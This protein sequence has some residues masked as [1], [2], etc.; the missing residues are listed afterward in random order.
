MRDIEVNLYPDF[1]FDSGYAPFS[2]ERGLA[3]ALGNQIFIGQCDSLGHEMLELVLERK[4]K[5]KGGFHCENEGCILNKYGGNEI[6]DE[7]QDYFKKIRHIPFELYV[8]VYGY[9]SKVLL[10]EVNSYLQKLRELFDLRVNVAHFEKI[11]ETCQC[12]YLVISR[13]N[14]ELTGKFRKSHNSEIY[15]L[16]PQNFVEEFSNHNNCVSDAYRFPSEDYE[17]YIIDPA[18]FEGFIVEG[19]RRKIIAK[20][21]LKLR[22]KLVEDRIIFKKALYEL[23]RDDEIEAC[24]KNKKPVDKDAT[25]NSLEEDIKGFTNSVGLINKIFEENNL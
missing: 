21:D 7:H 17:S 4:I 11:N 3:W 20:D 16:L 6:C 22:K 15:R 24:D 2:W 13:K 1:V 19:L 12:K 8:Y 5:N 23:V 25:M 9:E 14:W 10:E 18:I